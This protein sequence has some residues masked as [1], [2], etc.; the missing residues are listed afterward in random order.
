MAVIY[1]HSI[2][3][4][5]IESKI[6]QKFIGYIL[7]SMKYLEPFVRRHVSNLIYYCAYEDFYKH[8]KTA[9]FTQN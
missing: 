7:K 9:L 5:K 4:Y 6:V 8:E 3:I 1:I 2:N